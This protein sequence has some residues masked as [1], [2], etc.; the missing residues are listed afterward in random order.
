MLRIPIVLHDDIRSELK[1]VP[2]TSIAGGATGVILKVPVPKGCIVACKAR[3]FAGSGTN[4]AYYESTVVAKNVAGT[5]TL[6][7]TETTV[8]KENTA[9]WDLAATANDTSDT[10][11]Y[12]ATADAS[13][14]TRFVGFAEVI[15]NKIP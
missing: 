14:A 9:G 10:I 15:T 2:S 12:T 11:D 3:I 7:G 13:T 8:Q 5:T 1:S 6:I 4:G